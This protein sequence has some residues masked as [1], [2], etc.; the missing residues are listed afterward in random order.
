M[1]RLISVAVGRTYGLGVALTRTLTDGAGVRDSAS[2]VHNAD[3]SDTNLPWAYSSTSQFRTGWPVDTVVVPLT[4]TGTFRQKVLSTVA[5]AG[6]RVVV[7]LPAGIHTLSSF[8]LIGSSGDPQ[9]AFGLWTPNLQGFVGQGPDQTFIEMAPNSVS[10]AQLTRIAGMTKASGAPISMGML[11]IDGTAGKPALLS[12]LTMRAHDQQM[13]TFAPDNGIFEPQPCPHHG[14]YFYNGATAIAQYLRMTGASRACTSLP[15]FETSQI[16]SQRATVTIRN[17]EMDGRRAAAID[18]AR[19][20]RGSTV[21]GNSEVNHTL[22]DVWLHHH[23][24]SRYAA[25]DSTTGG[26]YTATRVKMEKITDLRNSGDPTLNGGLSLGG[27]T[28]ASCMGWESVGGVI[29]L[30]EPFLI[31]DNPN[32]GGQVP[33]HLQLTSVGANPRGGRM[34]VYG[35]TFRNNG[36][37]SIDGYLTIRIG[38]TTYWWTD[39]VAN[40]IAVY[41]ATGARKTAHQY[42]GSW[43]PTAGY[44]AANGL[45]PDTHYI[46]RTA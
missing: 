12:G 7:E 23:N 46:V 39:G 45:N 22:T 21:M 26:S 43:P 25:N 34:Y 38:A 2:E 37:P 30:N 27:W 33:C 10:A 16:T 5:A 8:E 41:S 36:F 1:A 35:G 24:V 17:T 14:V 4:G 11:R 19:P 32:V 28:D 6:Q 31:Q 9:Y 40:T 44:L 29:T 18:P 42:T 15:P 20:R 3:W 13:A